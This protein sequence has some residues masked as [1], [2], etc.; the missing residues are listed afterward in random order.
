MIDRHYR[1]AQSS[2]NP[3]NNLFHSLTSTFDQHNNMT[4]HFCH[5]FYQHI[6][7]LPLHN[8]APLY[9]SLLTSAINTTSLL[10]MPSFIHSIL[11]IFIL[12]KPVCA[13]SLV[14][15]CSTSC[16]TFRSFT[17]KQQDTENRLKLTTAHPQQ[18]MLLTAASQQNH[19]RRLA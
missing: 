11:I 16:W 14:Q 6:K 9:R 19:G 15:M 4:H 5:T 8:M 18:C 2:N 10:I 13:Y 3:H 17:V 1:G 12:H 7:F